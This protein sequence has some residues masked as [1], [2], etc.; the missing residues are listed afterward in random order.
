GPGLDLAGRGVAAAVDVP[1]HQPGAVRALF[2]AQDEPEAV[3]A[4]AL[5]GGEG[6]GPGRPRLGVGAAGEAARAGVERGL[7]PPDLAGVGVDPADELPDHDLWQRLQRG[8]D[9]LSHDRQRPRPGG[10]A[11]RRWARYPAHKKAP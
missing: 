3:P 2:A 8:G 6:L 7:G 11:F 4:A 10:L 9:V 5:V 1:A